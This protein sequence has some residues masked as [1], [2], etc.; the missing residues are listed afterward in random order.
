MPT[1]PG[2]SSEAFRHPLDY[3]AEQALRSVPGFD[4][5]ARKFVELTYERPR[6][7]F[8]M[9]NSI[10]VGPRQY[11][12]IYQSFRE[13]VRSLDISPEP[14]LF[15]TQS[16]LANAYAL[17]QER[18]CIV[19]NS[20]LLDLANEAELRSI[21]AHELGHI[22]CGHTTLTQMATWAI[23]LVSGLSTATFGLSTLVSTG[24][25]LA[26]YEWLRKAE[27]SADRASLLVMDDLNPILRNMML[28][29]G[30]SIQHQQELSLEEFIRQS[31][32][33]QNLDEDG[34][35]QVYKFFLYNNLS[36]SVFLTHPFTVERVHFLREWAESEEFRQI[37]QGSYRRTTEG[38]VNVPA[39]T[40]ETEADRLRRELADLQREI[41]RLKNRS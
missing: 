9:G 18:P 3:Q 25:I 37:R 24:L 23:T 35:N 32:R 17:G 1:Y 12:S 30:G 8:L 34:L 29:A 10:E 40:P 41:D 13:C 2:I 28:M 21:L 15:V 4:L 26:F 38:A 31:E 39:E 7:V 16:P 11:A 22:K 27:L 19:L 36:Q 6:Y 14:T 20:G 5:V 33:Y